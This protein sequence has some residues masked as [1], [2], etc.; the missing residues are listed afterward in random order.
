MHKKVSEYE[1]FINMVIVWHKKEESIA[2][3]FDLF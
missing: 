3:F 2:L 1:I